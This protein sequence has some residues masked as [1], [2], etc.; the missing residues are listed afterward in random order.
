MAVEVQLWFDMTSV[1]K[2]GERY[3]PRVYFGPVRL[4]RD[5]IS[6]FMHGLWPGHVHDCFV[7]VTDPTFRFPSSCI[8]TCEVD[9]VDANWVRFVLERRMPELLALCSNAQITPTLVEMMPPRLPRWAYGLFRIM[10]PLQ[11]LVYREASV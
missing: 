4:D 3:G 11:G 10:Q 2:T 7:L 6:A 1:H 5:A 9:G 8:I